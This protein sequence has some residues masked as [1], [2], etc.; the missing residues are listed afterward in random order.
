MAKPGRPGVKLSGLWP[1]IE[2]AACAIHL[3]LVRVAGRPGA[4]CAALVAGLRGGA[5]RREAFRGF[6]G[7][8]PIQTS[9]KTTDGGLG[10]LTEA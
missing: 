3:G 7:L 10:M 4:A 1:G 2:Y 9:A 8:R 5:R 6:H